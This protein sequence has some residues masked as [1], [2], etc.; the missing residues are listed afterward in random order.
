VFDDD[1]PMD[2]TPR[3]LRDDQHRG[4]SADGGAVALTTH[5]E[6]LALA[7]DASADDIRVMSRPGVLSRPPG[8]RA[9]RR[10]SGDE[11]CSAILLQSDVSMIHA[12]V[13]YLIFPI[14]ENKI[15]NTQYKNLKAMHMSCSSLDQ[16]AAAELNRLMLCSFPN[17]SP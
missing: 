15:R 1:D 3:P 16:Q 11:V 5:C 7:R 12:D 10:R 4:A 17:N 14:Y 6:C 8:R 13:I 2:R 9:K